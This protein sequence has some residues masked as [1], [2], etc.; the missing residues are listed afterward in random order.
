MR[1]WSRGVDVDMFRPIEGANL[2]Y[3]GPIWLYVGRVAVEK[4]LEAFLKLD[5]PGTKVVIGEG[6]ARA[7]LERRHPDA[8]FL[9]SRTGED[10]VRHYAA[11]DVFVFP[12]KTDTFGLVILEALA[13]G[14]PVAAF[15]VR[16]PC[17]VIGDAPVGSAARGFGR[18][19]RA[20]ARHPARGLPRLRADPVLARL[21][22]RVPGKPAAG[23]SPPR[24]GAPC[25]NIAHNALHDS[26]RRARAGPRVQPVPEHAGR[27]RPVPGQDHAMMRTPTQMTVQSATQQL[28]RTMTAPSRQGTRLAPWEWLYPMLVVLGWASLVIWLGKDTSW[29]FRNYHWYAPYAFL[30]GRMGFD[31]AVAHQA[32]Y[33]NPLLDV[34]F[35]WLA[36]HTPSWFAL[37]ALG[38]VQG[39]SVVPLYLIARTLLALGD[40]RAAAM[41]L[42]ALCMA[43]GLTISLAGTTYYDNVMSLPVLSG[44]A[45][46]IRRRETLVFGTL[47]RAAAVAA[48]AGLIIGAAIGLKLPEAPYAFGFAAALAVLPGD[49]RRQ[50]ARLGAG[51]IGG[52]IGVAL[53]AGYWFWRMDLVTGN[54]L[55]PY[56]N[57]F[58]HSPLALAA[59]YRDTRFLPHDVLHALLDP[60]LFSID[61]R[62]ADDLPYTDIRVGLAYV[63]LIATGIMWLARKRTRDPLTA[64][65]GTAALI[66]FV[67]MSYAAW[68]AVF[69]IYRYILALEMLAPIVIVAAVGRWP[70]GRPARWA[71]LA[72]LAVAAVATTRVDF[73]ERAPLGDPYVQVTWPPIPHPGRTMILMTG[74]APMGYLVPTL[75]HGI[76]IIRIDGWLIQPDDHSRLTAR[77][78]ARVAAFKGDL[79]LLANPYEVNRARAALAD[80][81]LAFKLEQCGDVEANLGGPYIFCPLTRRARE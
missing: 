41:A 39:A 26:P 24:P 17:D 43:G 18:G 79:E 13:C 65:D 21:H 51:A 67:A 35:Y 48:L 69:G 23:L 50:C 44:L 75:P 42:A 45:L 30:H 12:S 14:V 34:P 68:L 16:G 70:L 62:V 80:Y 22:R 28:P 40:N 61:W 2:P 4:N 10:L 58:F 66:A 55:F 36:T 11:A 15:P 57:E 49:G 6:P 46:V 32:S 74:E 59:S 9:G 19:L 31:I 47:T 53:T 63:L 7:G 78:E 54:P 1:I 25:R 71:V 33:Y 60:I 81:G 8:K 5:L 64:A 73:L 52:V 3:P 76:A 38:A 20:G 29:D 56:F 72:G 77:A 37:G 27:C